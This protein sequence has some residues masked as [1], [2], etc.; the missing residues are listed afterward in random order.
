MLEA[1]ALLITQ[2]KSSGEYASMDVLRLPL[3]ILSGMGFIGAGAIVRRGSLITGLTTAA[4]LW[5]VTMIGLC[6]G[7]G[8][9][10]LGIG[11][12]A[13]GWV[14]LLGLKPIE[15]RTRKEQHAMMSILLD[16]GGPKEET[17]RASFRSAKM[18]VSAY[19][20]VYAE[21][22]QERTL[23]YQLRWKARESETEAPAFL[24]EMANLPG[25]KSLTWK[26]QLIEFGAEM[27]PD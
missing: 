11:G 15:N 24:E 27:S 12:L 3:G 21:D 18:K 14:V 16:R 25:V 19:G 9:L 7:G 17:L 22:G 5:L 8:Q 20:I 4:T 6:F 10:G 26:P 2:G 13:V 1:N 23:T